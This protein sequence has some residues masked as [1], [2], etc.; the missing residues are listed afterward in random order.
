MEDGT[1][2]RKK[3]DYLKVTSVVEETEDHFVDTPIVV[4]T[5]IECVG[6][7]NIGL[8][9]CVIKVTPFFYRFEVEGLKNKLKM[10]KRVMQKL[11]LIGKGLSK[12][13]CKYQMLTKR[14]RVS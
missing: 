13:L 8:K 2:F 5:R 10:V 9:G 14:G 4:G 6:G 1:Y 7:T 11:L 12:G 3:K